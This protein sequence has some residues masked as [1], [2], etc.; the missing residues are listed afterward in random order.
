M[1]IPNCEGQDNPISIVEARLSSSR[2]HPQPMNELWL[3]YGMNDEASILVRIDCNGHRVDCLWVSP[4]TTN[5]NMK[6]FSAVWSICRVSRRF[7]PVG[8]MPRISRLMA[9]AIHCD[10][11]IRDGIAADQSELARLGRVT[12]AR[13]TQIMVLLN[14]APDILSNSRTDGPNPR[15]RRT[16]QSQLEQRRPAGFDANRSVACGNFAT[17]KFP[18]GPP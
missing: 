6:W 16:L 11:L 14:L 18:C 1:A 4:L 7:G 2:R 8:R 15:R 3:C 13:V 5:I 12:T 9:I 17:Q 10:K